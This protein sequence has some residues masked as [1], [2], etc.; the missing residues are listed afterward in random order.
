[1]VGRGGELARLSE[2]LDRTPVAVISGMGGVGKST[3]ALAYAQRWPGPACWVSVSPGASIAAVIGEVFRQLGV[4]HYDLDAGDAERLAEAA[5]LLDRHRALVVLDDLHALPPDLRAL[6][7][8]EAARGLGRGRLI[9]TSRELVAGAREGQLGLEP[10]DRTAAA[11]LCA[12]LVALFG[13]GL[14]FERAWSVSRGNPFL[15]RQAHI[16]AVREHNPLDEACASLTGVERVVAVALAL[17][18]APV[19]HGVL[20]ALAATPE[21]G[22][23]AVHELARRLIAE[24]SAERVYAMHA[25]MREA[26][27][28]TVDPD[29]QRAVRARLIDALR[30]APAASGREVAE[31]ARLLRA[32]DRF[33]ELAALLG[34]A[35]VMLVR[36]GADALVV[37]EL[38][39]LPAAVMTPRLRLLHARTLC[40]RL[41]IRRAYELLA[42]ISEGPDAG[43]ASELLL[44]NVATW[45]G[46]LAHAEAVL[47]ALAAPPHDPSTRAR[48]ALGLAWVRINRGSWIDRGPQPGVP[49]LYGESLRLCDALLREQIADGSDAAHVILER[50]GPAPREPWARLLLPILV[51][52]ML[53]RAGE[54]AE[55]E[56]VAAWSE[57]AFGEQRDRVEIRIARAIIA[58]ETGQRIANLP[59]LRG[60]IRLFDRGSF[61]AGSAW[62]RTALA[63][64][65][66]QLG[67]R[68]EAQA[69]VAELRA[70]CAERGTTAYAPGIEVAERQDPLHVRWLDPPSARP[71][72]SKPGAVVRDEVRAALRAVAVDRGARAE[73]PSI[74]IPDAP[75]FA[76]D[77]VCVAVARA[78]GARRHGQRRV[79]AQQLHRAS[80]EA[81]AGGVDAELV[82]MLYD[83][84]ERPHDAGGGAI[85][86]LVIDRERHE[87]RCGG[88]RLSLV[89]RPALRT[90]LY[91]FADQPT[92][93]LSHD[94]IAEALWQ[95]LYDPARHANTLKS[96]V[97]RLRV[98]LGDLG[99]EILPEPGGYR[100]ARRALASREI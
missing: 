36:D 89:A 52:P 33:A 87:V 7:V 58:I 23:R 62:T 67:R 94:D 78:V 64:T 40:H 91:A 32:A 80:A 96:A 50:I 68:R 47:G 97:R 6:V 27:L 92:G 55:A 65:L 9:A 13:P 30:A 42:A 72:A 88:R 99:V 83:A 98:V 44:G 48:A 100:L 37:R 75:D 63:R 8:A 20:A 24:A 10:L 16:G 81:S 34:D 41:H 51:A 82:A 66:Y 19:A 74:A 71:P 69:V 85:T 28:R 14:E 11:E 38:E 25:L 95:T 5:E 76:L 93:H 3:L 39:A 46:E 57:S 90:L 60:S 26:V 45:A 54:L 84:L 15:L 73:L 61:F 35:G 79:A 49:V 70:M 86:E 21:A 56:R 29:E 22:D 4:A 43:V 1:M 18:N 53:A 17:S 31:L 2:L 59:V 12:G 77:R